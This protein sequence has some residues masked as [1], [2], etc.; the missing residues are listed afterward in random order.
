[1]IYHVWQRLSLWVVHET[2][3]N[4]DKDAQASTILSTMAANRK[5]TIAIRP[6]EGQKPRKLTK[7]IGLNGQGFS[8]LTPYHAARSGYL[9][10]LPMDLRKLGERVIPWNEAIAFT[11]EDR[12]KLSYHIDGFAQFSSE[13]PGKII[14]GRDP[15]NGEPKGLGLLVRSLSS[16][17][18]SGPSVGV[19]AWG[20]EDFEE[21]ADDDEVVLFEP[22]DHYYRQC[23]PENANIWHLAIYAFP[24]GGI[25][26][27]QL[28]GNERVM[29]YQPHPITAGVAG[30]VIKMKVL[31]LEVEQMYLGLY[32][33]R[34]VGSFPSKSGWT[35]N[36]P[37]NYNQHQSGHVLMAIYPRTAI[38]SDDVPAL[39]RVG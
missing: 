39:D 18:V 29:L 34:A 27:L 15:K 22:Q 28:E 10:K 17:S 36:G 5:W 11:A 2:H 35:I 38:P 3:R 4:A 37:G 21:I 6:A 19:T 26:P 8:V 13:T 32:V 30:A 24:I 31:W 9:F 20:L 7:V 25:P 23:D 16:P 33:E 12:V 1:M 14:S